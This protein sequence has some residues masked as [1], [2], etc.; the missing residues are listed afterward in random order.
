VSKRI[1]A[2]AE[3]HH[4]L[5]EG[6][7]GNRKNRS[8]ELAARNVKDAVNTA[9]RR[10]AVASL[11]QLDIKGAFDTVNHERL[12]FIM[13]NKGY[14]EWIIKW[15][16]SFITDRTIRLRFDGAESAEIPLTAGVPQGSPLSPILFL[17]YIATLYEALEKHHDIITI[18]FADDTNLL[19]FDRE[20]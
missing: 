12:E 18:G 9:W 11:L 4:L 17:I 16:R 3:E 5:P 10:G 8:T 14:P 7:M 19:T 2:A 6:Q 1:A 20:A 13:R 15:I